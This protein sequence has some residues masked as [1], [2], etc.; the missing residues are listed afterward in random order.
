MSQASAPSRTIA[1]WWRD[2]VWRSDPGLMRTIALAAVVANVCIVESGGAVRLS[3]SGLGCPTWP[4]CT[5]N[6]LVPAPDA[7]IHTV[8]MLIEFGNRVFTI[9][10]F[11]VAMLCVW[12]AAR[13]SPRRRSLMAIALLL[14]LGVLV[15]A[16]LGGITVLTALNPGLVAAHFGVS[17]GLIAAAVAL[18]VRSGESDGPVHVFVRPELR[19]LARCV[20]AVVF[21]QLAIG[22]IVTGTGP[23]AGDARSPRFPFGIEQVAQLHTDA[24]WAMVGLTFA[25][26]FALHITGAQARLVRRTTELFALELAQ[27]V[28]GYVQYFLGV[29]APLVAVHI[30]AAALVWVAALRMLFAARERLPGRGLSQWGLVPTEIALH[31]GEQDRPLATDL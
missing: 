14:P 27:G 4:R 2:A 23:H 29:P 15:Q 28:V 8:N 7:G 30:L 24:G 12:V 20:V 19:W 10:V 17:M 26:L 25:L 16:V 3:Q 6:S 1:G 21:L 18:Y 9:L 22:T 5:A 13:L 31:G 11:V